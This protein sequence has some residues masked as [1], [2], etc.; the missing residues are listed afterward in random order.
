M[1]T[2]DIDNITFGSLAEISSGHAVLLIGVVVA[3]ASTASQWALT[4]IV[5]PWLQPVVLVVFIVAIVAGKLAKWGSATG[6]LVAGALLGDWSGG[7]A[8]AL[9]AFIATVVAVR[10][11]AHE[12]SARTTSARWHAWFIRYATAGTG[13]ALVFAAVEAWF[14]DM[15]GRISFGAIISR[16][17]VASL[18]LVLLGAPVAWIVLQRVANIEWRT[19]AEPMNKPTRAF[20]IAIASLWIVAGYVSSFVFRA[21]ELVPQ[22]ELGNRLSPTIEWFIVLWGPQGSYAQLLLGMVSLVTIG[23]VLRMT[24]SK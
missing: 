16:T 8:C 17:V 15:F 5:G 10:L 2:T 21:A 24:R 12:D 4:A 1:T 13:A 23:A 3:L 11:W 9:A 22:D 6:L 18:P 19:P 7:V 20:I 14:L